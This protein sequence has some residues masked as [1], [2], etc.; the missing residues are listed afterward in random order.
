MSN[1]QSLGRLSTGN[2]FISIPDI[3]TSD[4]GIRNIGF[5]HRNFRACIEL[6]GGDNLPLLKPVVEVDGEDLFSRDISYDY[7]SYW[8]PR[9]TASASK[10]TATSTI[11]APLDR[12]GF[13]CVMNI[14]NTSDS[15]IKLRA[16]W[17][18][19]WQ[20]SFHTANLSKQMA[21]TKHANMSS[22]RA[23]V[24]IVEF[25]GHTPLFAMALVSQDIMPA[26]IWSENTQSEITEWAGE[27][28]SV[29][30][31]SPICYEL[32][33]DYVIKPGEQKVLALYVGI[34]LEEVSAVAS[35]QEL[36]I[37]SWERCFSSLK[38][39]LDNHTLRCDDEHLQWVMNLNS[40]YNYFY[41][42]AITLDTEELV[43]T[44]ARSSKNDACASYRDRDAM[45]WSL[46]AVLQISWSQARNMLIYAFTTELRNVGVH[47]RYIDG[48]VLEPGLQL[49]QLCAPIRA[50]FIYVDLTGDLSVLFDRRVQ[51]GIN[52]IQQVL[53]AQ[54]HPET[55]L[56]ETLLL[57]SGEP[58]KYPYV[59]YSNVLVWR[60]LLDI[61]WL[62]ERI[63][64][65]DHADEAKALANQVR[66][67]V[68]QHFIVPGPFGD[69]FARAVDLQ[70]NY[71]LGDDPAGSLILLAHYYGFCSKDDSVYKNTVAWINSKH[72]PS[73][74]SNCA[75]E[76]S[77]I[78]S[79]SGPSILSVANDLISGYK[80]KALDI[81]KR[82]SM[83]DGIACESV[84]CNSGEVISGRAFAGCAGYL[85]FSL[86]RALNVIP[87]D[88]AVSEV[89]RHPS[90]TLYQPPPESTQDI[91]KARL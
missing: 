40:F 49:D 36:H 52:A 71:E 33:D 10:V 24:P 66:A 3:H 50:L 37:Q 35:A 88:T 65:I 4:A 81:L 5:L 68:V 46:P 77:G 87:P 63:R 48:I 43:I 20:S 76:S 22:W 38:T 14:G 56:F 31:G 53:A 41:S 72:N 30:S 7:I 86:R 32:A 67:A 83:D 34:G 89:K 61:V 29:Q 15:D 85:A 27:S 2:E 54:R 45:R 58:S 82:V 21:G 51:A 74:F 90:E 25:R 6:H 13:V 11:F 9:F 47:S 80:D 57:P 18:G 59:C 75:F 62:Y 73:F 69:M 28:I 8:I 39:W 70:G 84:D 1:K 12:R 19:C 78:P 23:G 16:G 42:Q 26:R 55:A 17:R 64:D 60:I 44:S 91:R 79:G